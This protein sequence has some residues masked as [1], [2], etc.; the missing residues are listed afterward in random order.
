MKSDSIR[1]PAQVNVLRVWDIT[2][3]SRKCEAIH[4][5]RVALRRDSLWNRKEEP[6]NTPLGSCAP[7]KRNVGD[8]EQKPTIAER[9]G[10]EVGQ[11]AISTKD[12]IQRI[13]YTTTCHLKWESLV[14]A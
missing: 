13:S 14:G 3:H 10:T 12:C 1:I 11:G 8:A 7:T 6:N 5:E 4:G 2:Q 9:S